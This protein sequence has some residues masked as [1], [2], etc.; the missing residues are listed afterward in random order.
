MKTSEKIYKQNTPVTKLVDD[1]QTLAE[2]KG[3]TFSRW[4]S[5]KGKYEVVITYAIHKGDRA[6][7]YRLQ[8]DVMDHITLNQIEG[9]TVNCEAYRK[10]S[11][12]KLVV[13]VI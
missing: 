2:S 3:Y 7:Q 1:I 10:L 8:H 5:N 11:R 13:E 4:Q 12:L 9:I 6:S